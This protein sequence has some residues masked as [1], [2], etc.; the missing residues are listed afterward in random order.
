MMIHACVCG[1]RTLQKS[2]RMGMRHGS[3]IGMGFYWLLANRRNKK[4]DG[5]SRKSCLGCS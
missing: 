1:V 2:Y 4:S 3:P 5:M